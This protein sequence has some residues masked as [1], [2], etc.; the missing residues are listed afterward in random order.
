VGRGQVNWAVG[1]WL[2]NPLTVIAGFFNYLEVIP[3][4]LLLLASYLGGKERKLAASTSLTIAALF[5]V[6]PLIAFP[7]FLATT[8]RSR[9]WRGV[10]KIVAPLLFLLA[11]ALALI[12]VVTPGTLAVIAS[13]SGVGLLRPEAYDVLGVKLST[14]TVIYP[15]STVAMTA[16]VYILL[17]AVVVWVPKTDLW[18]TRVLA[19]EFY[20]P[21]LAYL[22]FSFSSPPFLMYGI[23]FLLVQFAT[24]RHYR[25]LMVL[26][27]VVGSLWCLVRSPNYLI[28]PVS[29]IFYIPYYTQY[30]SLQKAAEVW[31]NNALTIQSYLGTQITAAFTA[32]ILFTMAV[33]LQPTWISLRGGAGKPHSVDEGG[34][35]GAR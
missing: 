29:T 12:E 11:G 7:F 5:R 27:S 13:G 23:P 6:V 1:A 8:V 4:F 34:R 25:G 35:V 15:G 20:L 30:W 19:E 3:A 28:Q 2:L 17:L 24:R 32:F 31:L 18:G 33:M 22:A 9:D 26:F 21:I 14:N 10:L 16:L